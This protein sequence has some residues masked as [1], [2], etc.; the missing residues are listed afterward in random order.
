VALYEHNLVLIIPSRSTVLRQFQL[1]IA[2]IHTLIIHKVGNED[3][4][5][6]GLSSYSSYR[7]SMYY[8]AI[9]AAYPDMNIIASAVSVNIQLSNA[10]DDH[11]YTRPDQFVSQFNYFDD[12][13]TAHKTLIGEYAN[14][15]DNLAG[16]GGANFGEPKRIWASW[17]GTVA[18]AVVWIGSERNTDHIIG[19]SYAP[20]LAN[21]NDYQWTVISSSNMP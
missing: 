20:L 18:E 11:Q 17:V 15:Q 12:F 1:C 4:L 6:G 16:G 21:L 8:N 10:G 13:S 2:S 14:I 5:N 7:F 3:N 9:K 19:A